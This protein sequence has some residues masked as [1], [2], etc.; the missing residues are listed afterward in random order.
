MKQK[1]TPP[2]AN[3]RS[4]AAQVAASVTPLSLVQREQR[5]KDHVFHEFAR[6]NETIWEWVISR[7]PR[8]PPKPVKV[9]IR[10]D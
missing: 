6:E 8:P 4:G 5:S 3:S 1:Q 2:E 10:N 9:I 7:Y